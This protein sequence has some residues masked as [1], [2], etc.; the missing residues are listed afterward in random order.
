L[1]KTALLCWEIGEALGHITSLRTVALALKSKGY[2]CVFALRDL[3]YAFEI[4][5]DEGFEIFQAPRASTSVTGLKSMASYAELLMLFGF[6]NSKVLSGQLLAWRSLFDAIN[7]TL[8]VL[9][10]APSAMLASR[11]LNITTAI[12]S[13][14]FGCPPDSP[15][16]PAFPDVQRFPIER[17]RASEQAVLRAANMAASNLKIPTLEHMGELYPSAY[18]YIAALPE[19]DH[20]QRPNANYI[21]SLAMTTRG[22]TP[23][24]PVHLGKQ[25][26]GVVPKKIFAYLKADYLGLEEV[27]ETFAK[28]DVQ[29]VAFI[30][31]LSE[32]LQKKW[33]VANI[34]IS[35][36]PIHVE[37]ALSQSDLFVGHGGSLIQAVLLAGVPLM[38]LPMQTEQLIASETAQKLGVASICPVSSIGTFKKILK[39]TLDDQSL[40]ANSLAFAERNAHFTKTTRFDAFIE[41]ITTDSSD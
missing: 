7:P 25:D 19:L 30:P 8:L 39:K 40:K 3:T 2:R 17:L 9:D 13:G 37:H 14:G 12:A 38:L 33:N 35:T 6:L 10:S 31:G 26:S 18:T 5:H 1:Q 36:Q 22:V 16:W 32:M 11:G 24:W 21:G 4:L 23:N 29:T 27:L 15:T 34:W 41:K 28:A 20:Y